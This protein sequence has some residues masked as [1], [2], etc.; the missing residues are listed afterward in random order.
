MLLAYIQFNERYN[1]FFTLFLVL[2]ANY[3]VLWL[4]VIRNTSPETEYAQEEGRENGQIIRPNSSSR[5]GNKHGGLSAV[6][7]WVPGTIGRHI[8]SHCL[9]H[10]CTTIFNICLTS[11]WISYYS[12]PIPQVTDI[13]DAMI[14]K[15]LF[16]NLFLNGVVVVATSNRPPEGEKQVDTLDSA[17]LK[18]PVCHDCTSTF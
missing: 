17:C 4:C 8:I 16:E 7:W 5:R 10:I 12:D 9:I 1:I 18:H 6:L 15:Q 3:H 14:L 13:A 11:W 2:L